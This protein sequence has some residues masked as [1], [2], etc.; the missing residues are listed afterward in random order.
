M[1]IQSQYHDVNTTPRGARIDF[2]I[3]GSL[4]NAYLGIQFQPVTYRKR[5]HDCGVLFV[6][7]EKARNPDWSL[8]CRAFGLVRWSARFAHALSKNVKAA[9]FVLIIRQSRGCDSVRCLSWRGRPGFLTVSCWYSL[10]FKEARFGHRRF[11]G[12]AVACPD[13][14]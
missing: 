13:R 6:G 1:K 4:R 14:E 12:C 2:E 7:I 9:W 10:E 11:T 3:A 5:P 8:G